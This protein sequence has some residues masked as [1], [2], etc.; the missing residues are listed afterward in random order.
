MPDAQNASSGFALRTYLNLIY[1]N[2]AINCL[3]AD[4]IRKKILSIPH[5]EWKKRG[6]SK[7]T[8][9]Y[10]KKNAEGD[11]PFTL[12]KHVLTRLDQ[13]DRGADQPG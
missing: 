10:M 8:L 4:D 1:L 2:Y 13:W 5:A 7:G 3:G 12:N 11:Q 6:F 9:H